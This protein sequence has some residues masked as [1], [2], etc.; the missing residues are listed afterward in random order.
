MT[1]G[2]AKAVLRLDQGG[3]MWKELSDRYVAEVE[4]GADSLQL[5]ERHNNDLE[6][7]RGYLL[8]HIHGE[9]TPTAT[10]DGMALNN[11][12]NEWE[13]RTVMYLQTMTGTK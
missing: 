12:V 1:K 9:A 13:E 8:D 10:P 3:A 4:V 2:F 5:I 11:A 7:I 6:G